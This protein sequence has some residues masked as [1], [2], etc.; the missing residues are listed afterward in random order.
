MDIANICRLGYFDNIKLSGTMVTTSNNGLII[1]DTIFKNNITKDTISKLRINIVGESIDDSSD[2]VEYSKNHCLNH[3]KA[4]KSNFYII[5]YLDA[6]IL[7]GKYNQVL[8][9]D[10]SNDI[11]PNNYT[12]KNNE[13]ET[14]TAGVN[15]QRFIEGKYKLD[16][17]EPAVAILNKLYIID[18]FRENGISSWI[19]NNIFEIIHQL[20]TIF[21]SGAVLECGDF[22]REAK[23]KFNLTEEEYTYFLMEHY[24]KCGY[25]KIT[26]LRAI[27]SGVNNPFILYKII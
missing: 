27:T 9:K 21:V 13:M 12:S 15:L 20:S 25:R 18:L 14:I 16:R 24:I 8:Y 2:I 1:R 5:G 19:H 22:N 4:G 7:K 6:F 3:F 17:G 26:D 23:D 10:I 11:V